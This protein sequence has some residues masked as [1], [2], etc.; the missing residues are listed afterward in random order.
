MTVA[1][2]GTP[3]GTP[4]GTAARGTVDDT[5]FGLNTMIG[6][7]C[8]FLGAGSTVLL[9][10]AEPGVGHG[11]ADHSTVLRRPLD[12]LRTT[13]SYVYAVTL[14]SEDDRKHIVRTTNKAHVPIRSATY[15]AFDPELQLWVAGTLYRN[16]ATLYRRFFGELTDAQADA[17]YRDSAVFGTALQVKPDMWPATR[18]EFDAYWDR[19]LDELSC[20]DQV[21]RFVHALLRGGDAPWYIKPGMPLNRLVTTGLLPERVR[22]DFELPWGPGRQRAFDLLMTIMPPVYR[23]IPRPIRWLPAKYYLWD[24]RRR[25]RAG[26]G[27]ARPRRACG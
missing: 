6:E 16:G 4:A 26:E 11:V 17:L 8:L 23:L 3:A 22:T 21:R 15:N 14:G 12:R 7:A 24:L 2:A 20:D 27:V 10:L 25:R 1:S 5:D 13:M 18:A 9:Q 19:K